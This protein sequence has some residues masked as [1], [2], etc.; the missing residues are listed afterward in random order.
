MERVG[1]HAIISMHPIN[2]EIPQV[3]ILARQRH[4][5]LEYFAKTELKKLK[6]RKR[7]RNFEIYAVSDIARLSQDAFLEVRFIDYFLRVSY[8]TLSAECRLRSTRKRLTRQEGEYLLSFKNFYPNNDVVLYLTRGGKSLSISRRETLPEDSLPSRMKEYLA[9]ALDFVVPTSKTKWL[10]Y[11]SNSRT[12]QDNSFYF[13]KWVM[14]NIGTEKAYYIIRRD[15]PDLAQL[16]PYKSNIVYYYSLKH[17]FMMLHCNIFVSSQGRYHAYKFRPYQSHYKKRVLRKKLVFLQHGVTAFKQSQFQ[18]TD[19][20]GGSNLV[21]TVSEA[22]KSIVEKNWNYASNEVAITGFSR[23][24]VLQDKS[25]K[26]RPMILVMPTWRNWLENISDE[27][28]N[29]SDFAI[30]YKKLLKLL[31]NLDCGATVTFCLHIKIAEHSQAWKSEFPNVTIVQMGEKPVNELLM[32]ASVLITDYSSVAWD[33]LYMAK[34]TIFYHFDVDKYLEHTGSFIDLKTELFGPAATNIEQMEEMVTMALR[35]QIG[36]DPA[37]HF[38]YTD[39]MNCKRIYE[40]VASRF[41][42]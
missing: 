29:N 2:G 13:F 7:T 3:E 11:E 18:K 19:P 4:G 27:D 38:K 32:E 35:G 21:I 39:R 10:M 36:A 41:D 5:D 33:F 34:P 12:A 37:K 25:D 24:D 22:E 26:N 40:E 28:F 1:I 30:A 16:Q 17:L 14:E 9:L 23:F 31:D 42:T 8:K 6:S 20:S 15:S